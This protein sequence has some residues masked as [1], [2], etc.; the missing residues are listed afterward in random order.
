MSRRDVTAG[1]RA[2]APVL[3]GVVPFSMITGVAAVGADIP[4]MHA[5]AMS[6][7]MFAGAS[8]LAA[9]DLI[10]RTAPVTVVIL[11]AIVINLRFVM[12]SASI[13]P[14]F[15][16]APPL[17]KWIGAYILTDQ[18]YAVSVAEFR[19]STP[20]ETSRI[21]FYLGAA[22]A[23]WITWQIGTVIGA[24]V[25]ANVPAGLSLEFAVPLTF[26]G[27]LFSML[28]DRPTELAALIAGV[29]SVLTSV[30]P[31]NLGL[32]VGASVGIVAAVL[33]ERWRGEF[34]KTEHTTGPDGGGGSA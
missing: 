13:A 22:G 28:E 15:R 1:A 12:Y 16:R 19:T 4:P 33:V 10:E 6:L 3:I 27:L 32:I 31:F 2:I 23:L 30:L 8:Q 34:P 20:A 7:I 29:T 14:Y 9:I 26:L 25:G 17:L 5:I 21:W 18:A 24:V 11:T